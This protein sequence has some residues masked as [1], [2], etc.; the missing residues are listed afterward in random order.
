KQGFGRLIRT[1]RDRGI[2][3]VLDRRIV[4]KGYGK[5]LLASLPPAGRTTELDAVRAFWCGTSAV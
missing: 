1:R 2:V 5:T 3:A 4:R